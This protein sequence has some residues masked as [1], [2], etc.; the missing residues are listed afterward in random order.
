MLFGFLFYSNFEI[1]QWRIKQNSQ[2]KKR[3]EET[4]IGKIYYL[5]RIWCFYFERITSSPVWREE[6]VQV[7]QFIFPCN[8]S[9]F[10]DIVQVLSFEY[11]YSFLSS[12]AKIFSKQNE[13]T[14]HRI[15]HLLVHLFIIFSLLFILMKIF[16]IKIWIKPNQQEIVLLQLFINLCRDENRSQIQTQTYAHIPS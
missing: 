5:M 15:L 13:R 9:M 8:C 3:M 14:M 16:W 11:M 6:K 7:F 10:T 1:L 12:N 2:I 4:K